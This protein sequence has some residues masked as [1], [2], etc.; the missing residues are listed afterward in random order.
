MKTETQTVTHASSQLS[1]SK[2]INL[3]SCQVYLGLHT[4]DIEAT[5][6]GQAN[7]EY[8]LITKARVPGT[9]IGNVSKEPKVIRL[10]GIGIITICQG[11]KN[12]E[13]RV[14]GGLESAFDEI[15]LHITTYSVMAGL[16]LH[17]DLRLSFEPGHRIES[18][19]WYMQ[20]SVPEDDFF[21]LAMESTFMPPEGNTGIAEKFD[22]TYPVYSDVTYAVVLRATP[23]APV[24]S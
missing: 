7:N 24:V 14:I 13:L 22:E 8:K 20:T 18:R 23:K 4:V 16:G 21:D 15:T 19:K 2:T 9:V 5:P 12:N 3:G 6:A 10:P 1:F 17:E 11:F